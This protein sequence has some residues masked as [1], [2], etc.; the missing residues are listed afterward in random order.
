MKGRKVRCWQS[1]LDIRGESV[2]KR[3]ILGIS[4]KLYIWVILKEMT[5]WCFVLGQN[6][7]KIFFQISRNPFL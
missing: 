5:K 6:K 2:S 7:K 1:I 3:Y 4:K